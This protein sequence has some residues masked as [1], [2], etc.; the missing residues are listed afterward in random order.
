MWK[1]LKEGDAFALHE[2]AAAGDIPV[3]GGVLRG[4]LCIMAHHR[5]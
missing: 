5:R 3:H 1:P 4:V 2:A